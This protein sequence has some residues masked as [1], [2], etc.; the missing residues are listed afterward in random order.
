M[1]RSVRKRFRPRFEPFD[2][3]TQRNEVSYPPRFLSR[4]TFLSVKGGRFTRRRR[5]A[6]FLMSI[7]RTSDRTRILAQRL[8][9]GLVLVALAASTATT[10]PAQQV[11]ALLE[12]GKAALAAGDAVEA[13]RLFEAAVQIDRDLAEA[14]HL[15][16][17]AYLDEALLDVGKAKASN[18][19]ALRLDPD[20]VDY[21]TLRL[22]RLHY[23]QSRFLPGLRTAQREDLAERI[24][25]LDSANALAHRVLG[26]IALS[27]YRRARKSVSFPNLENLDVPATSEALFNAAYLLDPALG[28]DDES[29][30]LAFHM[31]RRWTS[32]TLEYVVKQSEADKRRRRAREHLEKA[33]AARPED[34]ASYR[35][36]M[37]LTMLE[38]HQ[39]EA[40]AL[41][42][43]MID[44]VPGESDAWLFKGVVDYRTGQLDEAESAFDRAVSLMS[45]ADAGVFEDASLII[46]ELRLNSADS[47][48]WK[49]K[50]PFLLTF[51]NERRLEHFARLA[52]ADLRFGRKGDGV[53]GWDTEPGGVVVRYGLP[54]SEAQNATRFDRYLMLH[55]GSFYFKFMELAKNG[56]LTFYS[57]GA[58]S[59]A[60]NF[61]EI[62]R[63]IE[64]DFTLV[65][66]RLFRE[67]PERFVYDANGRRVAFPYLA[68]TF[69]GTEGPEVVVAYGIPRSD[70]KGLD[71]ETHQPLTSGLFVLDERGT[72]LTQS[73]GRLQG[74]S[75]TIVSN[76]DEY[77]VWHRTAPLPPVRPST[78]AIEF[79]GGGAS[80]VGFQRT[81]VRPPIAPQK[82][83]ALSDVLLAY[84]VE[85]EPFE[86]D[87][88]WLVRAGHAMLP[89]PWGVFGLGQPIYLYFETYGIRDQGAGSGEIEVEA[90][91]RRFDRGEDVQ[92]SIDGLFTDSNQDAV[93]VRYTGMASAGRD[94]RYLILD[95]KGLDEGTYVVGL[96]LTE[97]GTGYT[98]TAGRA[99]VLD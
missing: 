63:S 89:A 24:L 1:T 17:R 59:A 35:A 87:D 29:K 44:R 75:H 23:F 20:N 55:Y 96:R 3:N 6:I 82:R 79:A 45:P 56:E 57:P 67:V 47:D 40:S 48:R 41:A 99:V 98:A 43:E 84:L 42:R 7:I 74:T 54:V 80:R 93:S 25:K 52:Y 16:A 37:S 61:N 77:D 76:E 33:V 28:E 70:S 38:W 39:E 97:T 10:A 72:I 34:H 18:G 12:D 26:E 90:R 71:P 86:T 14:H 30:R 32:G 73:T 31:P 65:S 8:I 64:N 81:V 22:H 46:G 13:A 78:V 94:S 4:D 69:I 88:S 19:R 83:P 60:P 21:L 27:D 5:P 15:L 91:L 92:E 36:L 2:D 9:R 51:S 62:E 49:G 11:D 95:T 53:R 68:S 66:K 58:G 85:E 50:D